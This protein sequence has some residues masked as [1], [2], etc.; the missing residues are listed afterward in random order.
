MKASGPRTP[1]VGWRQRT[2]ASARLATVVARSR[3]GWQTTNTSPN[4]RHREVARN[5][6]R[7]KT[8]PGMVTPASRRRG[9]ETNGLA[10]TDRV[11]TTSSCTPSSWAS[12]RLR[13]LV[14]VAFDTVPPAPTGNHPPVP[15]RRR[16]ATRTSLASPSP[17]RSRARAPN[18]PSAPSSLKP[19]RSPHPTNTCAPGRVWTLPRA[20]ACRGVRGWRG[21]RFR[22]TDLACSST[23][24]TSPA[25]PSRSDSRP[26]RCRTP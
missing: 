24:G 17:A 8:S 21:W 23:F 14:S 18:V 15:S 12:R 20:P 13:A 19:A 9:P 11:A 3:I 7:P 5:T 6:R 4:A 10:G 1:R 16:R 22:V 26:P 2:R 25:T